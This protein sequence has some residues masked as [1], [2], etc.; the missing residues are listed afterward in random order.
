ML[1]TVLDVQYVNSAMKKSGERSK[2]MIKTD[3]VIYR[4]RTQEEY[5]IYRFI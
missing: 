4:V 2:N 5:E 3:K 1:G